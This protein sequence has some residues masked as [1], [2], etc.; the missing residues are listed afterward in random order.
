MK[1]QARCVVSLARCSVLILAGWEAVGIHSLTSL[2]RPL[3]ASSGRWGCGSNT[4][5]CHTITT[6]LDSTQCG[7]VGVKHSRSLKVIRFCANR[8]GIYNFLLVT[9]CLSSTVLAIS[10]LACT[11]IPHAAYWTELSMQLPGSIWVMVAKFH[12]IPSRHVNRFSIFTNCCLKFQLQHTQNKMSKEDTVLIKVEKGCGARRIMTEIPGRN[13]SLA[14]ERRTLW[15]QN[16]N[17][18]TIYIDNSCVCEQGV[19]A[20]FI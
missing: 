6:S 7:Y 9:W 4:F 2:S 19:L 20:G 17:S 1:Q 10:R 5:T 18:Q 13:W 11:S 16:L 8:R 12:V 3:V 15:S 14:S